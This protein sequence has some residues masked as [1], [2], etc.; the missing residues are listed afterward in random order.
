MVVTNPLFQAAPVPSKLSDA[1]Q[2]LHERPLSRPSHY[3][4]ACH[5]LYELAGAL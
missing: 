5:V 2:F 1:K 3:Q 4:I